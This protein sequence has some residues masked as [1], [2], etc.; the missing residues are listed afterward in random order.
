MIVIY[1]KRKQQLKKQTILNMQN[2]VAII[3]INNKSQKSI[4]IEKSN[5]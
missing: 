1:A 5:K 4:E 3:A 2:S